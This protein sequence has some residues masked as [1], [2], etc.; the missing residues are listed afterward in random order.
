[1]SDTSWTVAYQASLPMGFS[2]QEYWSGLPC[3]SPRDLPDTGIKPMCLASPT[4]AG[5]FF[6]FFLTPS[7]TLEAPTAKYSII[8]FKLCILLMMLFHPFSEL[9]RLESAGLGINYL[10]KPECISRIELWQSPFS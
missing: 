4:L 2:R 10:L 5:A 1:M 6:F 3:S 9:G 7:A 8:S